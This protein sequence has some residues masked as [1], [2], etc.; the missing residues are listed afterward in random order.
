MG[1]FDSL[2]KIFS[3]DETSPRSR[4]RRFRLLHEFEKLPDF[5]GDLA[6]SPD[7]RMLA[8][9][10]WCEGVWLW[11][12][13]TKSRRHILRGPP[14][15]YTTSTHKPDKDFGH[16][17]A[18]SPDG[19]MLIGGGFAGT[20]CIWHVSDGQLLHAWNSDIKTIRSLVVSADGEMVVCAGDGGDKSKECVTSNDK[21]LIEVWRVADRTLVKRWFG[22]N[23]SISSLALSQQNILA[24]G[25]VD[26]IIRL[27]Q[28]PDGHLLKELP[29][30]EH[31]I[32]TL[33]YNSDGSILASSGYHSPIT[34]WSVSGGEVLRKIDTSA[35]VPQ[36]GR[37]PWKPGPETI[38]DIAFSPDG[39]MLL[40]G[41][42]YKILRLWNIVDC[43]LLRQWP[44]QE[45]R[46]HAVAF[47]HDGQMIAF[48]GEDAYNVQV[49]GIG[50]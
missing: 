2:K 46:I 15:R 48:Q 24:S 25:G 8:A 1:F 29:R 5:V 17:I 30:Q 16:T 39:Q 32:H 7:G 42:S 45:W 44:S 37:E 26:N 11:E 21:G 3:E 40:S 36:P 28:M 34:L 41:G 13:G 31:N 18:F 47:S 19:Q 10:C 9:G 49:W 43:Q 14:N 4:A 12:I 20:I 22:S 35:V 6:F 33:I 27:W 50:Q 23:Q 38:D